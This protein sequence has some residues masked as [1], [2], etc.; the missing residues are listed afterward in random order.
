[1][2]DQSEEEED[3]FMTSGHIQDEG[4]GGGGGG[5][6]LV[7]QAEACQ[8]TAAPGPTS[9]KRVTVRAFTRA[10]PRGKVSVGTATATPV[11]KKRKQGARQKL[12]PQ[13]V[14][15]TSAELVQTI[16]VQ[17]ATKSKK[18]EDKVPVTLWPQYRIE[19]L[20]GSFVVVSSSESWV[21]KTLQVMRCRSVQGGANGFV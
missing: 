19:K 15:A 21:E 5:A 8:V 16:F 17:P 9:E 6:P 11:R 7:D 1:M 12:I 4:A 20:E 13:E 2:G 18:K 3:F 14:S 10:A